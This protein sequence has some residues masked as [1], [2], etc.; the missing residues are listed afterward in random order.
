MLIYITDLNLQEGRKR[1]LQEHWYTSSQAC[2]VLKISRS[3]LEIMRMAQMIENNKIDGTRF[4]YIP[5]D[6]LKEWENRKVK[7]I[8]IK[9]VK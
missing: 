3:W 8:I 1:M 2:K 4:W 7:E 9:R 6:K 5:P